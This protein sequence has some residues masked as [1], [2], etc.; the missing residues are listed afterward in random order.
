MKRRMLQLKK[1][2]SEE[3]QKEGVENR[4][5]GFRIYSRKTCTRKSKSHHQATMGAKDPWAI[6]RNLVK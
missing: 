1:Q 2:Q 6:G 4:E 3:E 5:M